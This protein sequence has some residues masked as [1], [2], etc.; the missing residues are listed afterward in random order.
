[1]DALIKR[2]LDYARDLRERDV[3]AGGDHTGR[4]QDKLMADGERSRLA[5]DWAQRGNQRNDRKRHN[6]H[7]GRPRPLAR[8]LQ[9]DR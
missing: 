5:C 8:D 7:A 9:E 4:D 2:V 6:R 1:M 3:D